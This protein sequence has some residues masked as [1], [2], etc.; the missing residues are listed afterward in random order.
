MYTAKNLFFIVFLCS[1]MLQCKIIDPPEK[2]PTFIYIDDIVVNANTSTQGTSSDNI[3]DAWIYVN[4]NLIGVYEIPAK[5]PII[6]EGNFN[7]KIYPGIK[8]SG[9]VAQREIYPFYTFYEENIT[10]AANNLDTLTPIVNYSS[11]ADFW[12]EDFEDPGVKLSSPPESD[13]ILRIT[14]D[15]SDVLEGNGSGIITFGTDDLF[16]DTRTSEPAFDN[17][18]KGGARIYIEL[19]YNTNFPLTLGL[20]HGD[21]SLSTLVKSRYITLNST[22]GEWKKIYIDYTEEVSTKTS[23]TQHQIY[24]QVNPTSGTSNI[25]LLLDN[26]KVIY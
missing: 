3:T 2:V 4:D 8:R 23:A 13:T 19:E 18:P 22:N 21:A 12:I 10:F 11:I 5:I 7:L 15:P 17:F 1:L 20:L 9:F 26:I 16:F 25:K 24:F 6:A 14:T